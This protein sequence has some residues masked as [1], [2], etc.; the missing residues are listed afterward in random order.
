MTK[1]I[2]SYVKYCVDCQKNKALRHRPHGDIAPIRSPHTP[3]DTLHIDLIT[4]L[5]PCTYKGIRVD[6]I[7][8]TTCRF[9]KAKR[10]TPGRKDWGAVPWAAAFYEDV[11]LRWGYPK[12]LVTDRDK[13]FLGKFWQE[14]TGKAAGV[15]CIATTAYHPSGD[16]LA[17]RSNQELEITL[18][19]FV[20]QYQGDWAIHLSAI[21]AHFNNS[22][23]EETGKAPNEILFGFKTRTALDMMMPDDPLRAQEAIEFAERREVIRLEAAD[24][25]QM[26]RQHMIKAASRRYIKPRFDS[27]YA[28][29]NLKKHGF[30]LPSTRKGK[31]AQQRVG[32][33][34]ILDS[35]LGKGNAMRLELPESYGI[36]DVISVLH[37]EPAPRSEDDPFARAVPDPAPEVIDG[38]EEW[39]IEKVLK[40]KGKGARTRYLVR[41][42]GYPPEEDSWLSRAEFGNAQEVLKDF[43]EREK[44]EA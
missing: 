29:I 13:R 34:K 33:F 36:H 14:V 28:Y 22:V 40:T 5:P 30:K 27:G 10:F 6:A 7:M 11:V 15:R 2:R 16:G 20:D 43:E 44:E 3:F 38:E 12:T 42:E 4:D 32:P 31:L 21:E 37:L 17:E 8:T 1:S 25:I 19:F 18:R 39:V 9:S 35:T 23:S 26:G 41:W 24:A